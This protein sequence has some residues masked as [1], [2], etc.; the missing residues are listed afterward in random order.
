MFLTPAE[1]EAG[2]SRATVG[3]LRLTVYTFIPDT[4]SLPFRRARRFMM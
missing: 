2:V 3:V 1:E 4:T